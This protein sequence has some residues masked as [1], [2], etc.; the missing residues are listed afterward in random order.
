MKVIKIGAATDVELANDYLDAADW[1]LFD[2]RPPAQMK[3]ALPGGNAVSFDWHWLAGRRWRLPWMLSGGLH[4]GNVGEAV[5]LSGAG[6]VDVSSG[7][8]DVPGRK[9]PAKVTEFLRVVAALQA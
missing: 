2:A 1:L 4:A 5:R 3:G 6:M 9:N 7:V 8:E